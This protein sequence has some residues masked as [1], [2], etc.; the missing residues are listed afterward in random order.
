MLWAYENGIILG[1]N[2]GSFKPDRLITREQLATMLHRYACAFGHADPNEKNAMALARYIDS[3]KVS[4]FAKPAMR[5]AVANGIIKG[6]TLMTL[7][8]QGDA[9]RAQCA[10]ILARFDRIG[11]ALDGVTEVVRVFNS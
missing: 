3:G 8:P 6:K 1:Y 4:D 7:V 11:S 2:D 9:T 10:T 5:W